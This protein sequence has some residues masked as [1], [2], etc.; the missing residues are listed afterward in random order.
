MTPIIGQTENGVKTTQ[1]TLKV[2]PEAVIYDVDLTFSL[3]VGMS[4]SS[5]INAM[6]H[7]VEALYATDTNPVVAQMAE[8]GIA[9]LY[10]SQIGRAH[11]GTPVNNTQPVVRLR[12]K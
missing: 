12:L 1:R 3:P 2:L 7:A 10:R 5:G 9:A 4:V 11:V 8:A 6:A